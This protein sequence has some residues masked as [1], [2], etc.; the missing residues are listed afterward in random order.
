M[1]PFLRSLSF[2]L[3]ILTAFFVMLS[4]VL[5]YTP[6]IARFRLMYLKE[7]LAAAHL[8][9][10]ALQA[11]PDRMVTEELADQLLSH[12]GAHSIVARTP[13]AMN[14][15]SRAPRTGRSMLSSTCAI[16]RLSN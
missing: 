9:A 3:L 5:I 2:R 4:E 7:R 13:G 14:A 8:A 6:S 10:L 16:T 11:A 12:A 15:P 1:A